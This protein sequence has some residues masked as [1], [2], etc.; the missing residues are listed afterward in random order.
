MFTNLICGTISSCQSP[1][2]SVSS[3]DKDKLVTVQVTKFHRH[4][5]FFLYIYFFPHLVAQTRC[6]Q[7]SDILQDMI[8]HILCF[9]RLYSLTD[10]NN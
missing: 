1:L 6:D 4:S 7:L 3:V 9:Y 10:Q 8:C 2:P 5:H